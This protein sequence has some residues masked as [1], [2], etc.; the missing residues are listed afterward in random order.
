MNDIN[1]KILRVKVLGASP[2]ACG[3]IEHHG[4]VLITTKKVKENFC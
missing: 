3:A 2:A 4:V 1:P